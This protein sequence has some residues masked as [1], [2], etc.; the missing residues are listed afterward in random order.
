M[1]LVAEMDDSTWPDVFDGT[2][3]TETITD[4]NV[5]DAICRLA[6]ITATD[7]TASQTYYLQCPSAAAVFG[8]AIP[9]KFVVFITQSTGANLESTGDPNQVY[10][11]GMYATVG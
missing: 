7:T 5:R 9:R 10:V 6:A 8:G 3:S 11:R 1:Y 4:T 2:E